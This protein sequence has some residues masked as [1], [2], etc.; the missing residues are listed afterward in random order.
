MKKSKNGLNISKR[1]LQPKNNMKNR[2][3]KSTLDEVQGAPIEQEVKE[4]K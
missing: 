3:Q 2:L 4:S 1:V